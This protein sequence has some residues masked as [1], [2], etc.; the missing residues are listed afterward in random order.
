MKTISHWIEPAQAGDL[1]VG[2]TNAFRLF[3]GPDCWVERFGRTALISARSEADISALVSALSQWELRVGWLPERTYKRL[4]VRGPGESDVPILIAGEAGGSPCEI[5][6]ESGLRFEV[7]F[8]ASYSP[9]L[10]CDQRANRDFLRKLAP[11]RTLNTFAYT[12]AFSVAAAAVG[13]ATVSVDISKA[14]LKR[15]R[16]NFALNELELTP[17]REETQPSERDDAG[18]TSRQPILPEADETS[19]LG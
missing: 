1:E 2:G 16:R 8:S 10:F 6:L 13:S 11:S 5:V 9:G 19:A 18:L 17:S 4:L 14:S 3:S 12:C 15:G 7:D